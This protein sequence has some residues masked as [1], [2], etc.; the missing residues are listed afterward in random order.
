MSEQGPPHL[1]L[2]AVVGIDRDK[3]VNCHACISACPVKFCNDGSGDKVVLDPD[4]CIGCG[5]CLA[6]CTHKARYAIDDFGSFL[7][8]VKSGVPMV[9]ITAPSA[10]ANFPEQYLHL[11]GWLKSLGVEAVFDV[12]FGAELAVKS[13]VEYIRTNKPR[14]VISQPCPV[15]VTFIQLY[16]PE[17]LPHLIPVDSPMAHCMK[18]IRRFYPSFAGHRIVAISPCVAKKREFEALGLGDYNVGYTSVA[19]HL[20]ERGTLLSDFPPE[21]YDSS[22]AERAV[23]FST[24]GGL[25]RSLARWFPEYAPETRQVEGAETTYEYLVGLVQSIKNDRGPLLVDCLNCPLGCNGGPLTLAKDKPIDEVEYWIERRS[26]EMQDHYLAEY[27]EQEA[28]HNIESVLSRYWEPGLY[29][30]E[31]VDLHG[32]LAIREPSE[33]EREAILRRMHKYSSED[34]YNCTACGYMSC[35]DM[36]CAIHNGKNKPENC[37]FFLAKETAL[38]NDRVLQRE[39]RFRRILETSLEG[40]VQ[41]G[42]DLRIETV[43][44]A[45][46]QM[47][48]YT[49]EELIG[50]PFSVLTENVVLL[51][52]LLPTQAETTGPERAGEVVLSAKD[53]RRVNTLFSAC[54]LRDQSGNRIGTFALISD[55][56]RLKLTEEEL[57]RSRDELEQRVQERTRELAQSNTSLLQEVT[58]RRETEDA[59]RKSEV[60]LRTILDGSPIPQFVIDRQ[61][62]VISWNH[63]LQHYSGI[64]AEEVLGTRDHWRAFYPAPRPCLVDLLLDDRLGDI[65]VWYKGKYA[66]SK[67]VNGAFEVTDFFPQMLGVGRWLHFTAALVLDASGAVVGAVETLEDITERKLAEE[68]RLELERQIQH[69]QKLESLGVLAGGIA[70]DFNNLLAAIMGNADLALVGLTPDSP[71][72][73]HMDT[74]VSTA[75]R[76]AELASQML[77]YSGKGRY[78]VVPADLSS[79][80]REMVHLLEVSISKKA[81]LKLDL[82]AGLPPVKG[83]LA[84]LRQV[85]MNL[86]TNASEAMGSSAGEIR[87]ATSSV[88]LDALLPEASSSSNPPLSPGE[89]VALEVADTGCGMSPETRARIFEPFFTTKFTGRGLGLSAVMGIVRGHKGTI[90]VESQPGQGTVFRVLLPA[91]K[92]VVSETTPLPLHADSAA[93]TGTVL[94]VDDEASVRAAAKRFLEISGFK[95]FVAG[96]GREALSLFRARQTELDCVILDLMMPNMDG[97]ETRREL[98]RLR[99]SIPIIMSSGYGEEELARR[100]S[101]ANIAGFLQKPCRMETLVRLVQEV[102]S[103]ASS[104][105]V[106]ASSN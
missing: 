73:P 1:G 85:I 10:A 98:Q 59:L 65:E 88:H 31:Y 95:V 20:A 61:H 39:V 78:V 37:H 56:T 29:D 93:R 48:G 32:S 80:V 71:V 25:R 9:A 57:R 82:A 7:D 58:L 99:P 54:P 41:A 26:R 18:M 104:N 15:I 101:D 27:G 92:E 75:Q 86:I 90:E 11:N 23:L 4:M 97:D 89:Y 12:S 70:H 33:E 62:R 91:S 46:C 17:L 49:A 63:S 35:K 5:N 96:D 102:I 14:T 50:R 74:I 19:K 13:Y 53:G 106:R 55:I 60:R 6:A 94:I 68:E 8:D 66:P 100:Y 47:L 45:L 52:R 79:V 22:P 38:A 40:F 83:D 64:S 43:N 87:I 3:C 103:E 34:L 44:E 2:T 77:A 24:P 105:S 72:R 81:S 16:H 21:D 69:T 67:L 30:R 42:N 51:A 36:A 76:A 84:Q 28:V